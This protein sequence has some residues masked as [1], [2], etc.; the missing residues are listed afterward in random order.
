MKKIISVVLGIAALIIAFGEPNDKSGFGMFALQILA[1]GVLVGI[2]AI[3]G[4]F[5]KGVR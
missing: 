5:K 3:N 4:A 1:F 2:A